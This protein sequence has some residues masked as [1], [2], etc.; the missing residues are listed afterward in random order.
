MRKRC[1]RFM[2][3]LLVAALLAA[4]APGSRSFA[5]APEAAQAVFDAADAACE[6]MVADVPAMAP[7]V[8]EQMGV[9]GWQLNP[10]APVEAYIRCDIDDTFLYQLHGDDV[11]VVEVE[12]FDDG[13]GGFCLYYDSHSGAKGT[14]VQLENTQAW[15][16]KTFYLYDA[17]FGNRVWTDDF[18]I[19]VNRP[20]VMG[21]SSSPVLIHRV[22]VAKSGKS[23]P[24]S[25]SAST[26]KTGNIFFE[27]DDVC[28]E[29]SYDAMTAA[30]YSFQAEYLVKDYSG[31]TVVQHQTTLFAAP[32][33]H[34]TLMV[35]NLPYGVYQL[36]VNVSSPMISQ[37]Y[38]VDFS[39]SRKADSRNFH[40]G[41]NT[42]FDDVIYDVEDVKALADLIYNSGFGFVR[43]SLRWNQIEQQKGQYAIP[44]TVLYANQY[45]DQIGL[46]ML[47]IVYSENNL[48]DSPPYALLE[49][50]QKDAFS[51]YCNYV[52]EQL[53]DVTDY[54]CVLN[55]FNHTAE[56]YVENEAEYVGIVKA[57]YSGLRAGN[58]DA[59]INGGSL[60]G[61]SRDYA[62]ETYRLGVLDYC[63]SYSMHIYDHLNG[64]ETYYMYQAE[65]DHKA[66]LKRFDTTGTKQAWITESG[67]P[68]RVANTPGQETVSQAVADA[69]NSSTELEQARWYVRSMAING[70]TDRIDK[71]FFYS[72][73]DDGIDAFDVQSN[74]GIVHSKTYTTPFAAKPAY[75]AV[76]AY[77]DLIGQAQF[78]RDVIADGSG[79]GNLYRRPDGTEV[80]CLWCTEDQQNGIY[81]YYSDQPYTVVYDMYGNAAYFENQNGACQIPYSPE[82]V[83]VSGTQ[84]AVTPQAPSASSVSG[85]DTPLP[86]GDVWF[87]QNG[88]IL[89]S[90]WFLNPASRL[91]VTFP[92]EAVPGTE[93]TVFCAYYDGN[94]LGGVD[95]VQ[96]TANENPISVSFDVGRAA[97]AD[98]LKLMVFD[99]IAGLRPLRNAVTMQYFD[100]DASITA[101]VSQGICVVEGVEKSQFAN[102]DILLTVFSNDT[103]KVDLDA[104]SLAEEI[105]YQAQTKTDGDGRYVFTFRISDTYSGKSAM[106]M[107]SSKYGTQQS[108]I[109]V[110]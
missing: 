76:C 92:V 73:H 95:S 14:F 83:F 56:G 30:S 54:Y 29:I 74:F 81:T 71:F 80:L 27:G 2:V 100:T 12:Y 69:H 107:I 53:K 25:I 86:E 40:F 38:T 18:W 82:P 20:D 51:A 31:E 75:I 85:G 109:P 90:L 15:R 17:Y 45:L 26:G 77:N 94:T 108:V 41:T 57:A 61:W 1:W 11:P 21:V 42:H 103:R 13:Y 67:W 3:C 93:M 33:A 96:V 6:G 39:Y 19:S 70:D 46:E 62:N 32:S 37:A 55:E 66:N 88:Q 59:F 52:A 72:F 7:V 63:D 9:K 23:A 60:A 5:A 22:A 106:V 50:E 36:C 44:E 68:T 101:T 102:E 16:T 78:V 65:P 105:L 79:Y 84:Y 43:S 8:E 110:V 97:R 87:M 35:E 24:F 99:S 47:A 4:P 98:A 58:A 49:Q 104:A 10:E 28:F 48:Y 34:D 89:P 64:P 91:D